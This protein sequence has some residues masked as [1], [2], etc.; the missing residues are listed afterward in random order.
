MSNPVL[1]AQ[2]IEEAIGTS[3][4]WPDP[5]ATPH[6]FLAYG[7]RVFDRL[8]EVFGDDFVMGSILLAG[9]IECDSFELWDQKKTDF[10]TKHCNLPDRGKSILSKGIAEEKLNEKSAVV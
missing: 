8:L 4:R 10:D 7:D 5:V 1:T 2:H 3:L 9:H 6:M